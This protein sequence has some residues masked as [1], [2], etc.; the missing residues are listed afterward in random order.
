MKKVASSVVPVISIDRNGAKPVH[1]QIYD[2]Y[3][4]AI[5]Q[6]N[7][8]PG[9]KIPSTRLF[10]VELGVSRYPV[11]EAYAQLVAEGY[12]ESR[13]G[14][15]TIVSQNL[16]DRFTTAAPAHVKES[17]NSPSS[18]ISARRTALV[19]QLRA[20]HWTRGLGAFG[21]GQVAYDQFPLQVW[22]RLVARRTRKMTVRS[23]HYGEQMGSIMLR[24]TV[25]NYL[26]IARSVHCE[27]EQ[28]MIVS[29][30][31][32]AIAITAR[33]LLD[34]GSSIWIEEP[35]YRFGADV[36]TL[37]GCNLVPVPVDKEGINVSEGIRRDRMARAALVTPSHQFPLGFTMSAARRLQLL[38]WAQDHG[39][40]ILEDD[41][42]SEYRYESLPIPSLQ[43][44]DAHGRVIYIGT[45]SKVLFPS[46]RLGYLVIP[47]DL[48]EFFLKTR[49]AMDLAPPTFYQDVVADFI[50]EGHF[51][52]HIRRMRLLY[53]ERRSLL[54]DSISEEF[55]EAVEIDG[56]E[57]GMHLVVSFKT[58]I[59][60]RSVAERA[61]QQNLWV[62]PLTASYL[63]TPEKTGF[64]L[65]FGSTA[66]SDIPVAVRSLK[67]L[68][69]EFPSQS[70][71]AV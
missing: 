28:I 59:D 54:V 12:F 57:A 53:R 65:G 11:I 32:Q 58:S 13:V 39:A 26:R 40:W 34:P 62:W 20:S 35:G 14:A 3:R 63:K 70:K 15:A 1:R 55:G 45:F 27:P 71:T 5:M 52:R 50:D 48:I 69:K 29:G 44:M 60:D 18:R 23:F 9:Q 56:S 24:Q 46:L 30:S 66:S 21:V 33:V 7:L 64:I 49:H 17:L 51:E 68:V 22:S 42:D 41:Y 4:E 25:A 31:Q 8:R 19:G 6:G 47:K 61:G 43:G 67:K 36:F 16:P 2:S 38:T 10:A 37:A